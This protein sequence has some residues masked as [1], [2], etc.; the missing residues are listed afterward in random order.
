MAG[1][2][3]PQKFSR[4]RQLQGATVVGNQDTVL[5]ITGSH[6]R[7]R[8][9][10]CKQEVQVKITVQSASTT[11]EKIRANQRHSW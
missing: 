11:K 10:P 9:K 4:E 6:R 8:G 3:G 7:Q 5:E 2:R 1:R